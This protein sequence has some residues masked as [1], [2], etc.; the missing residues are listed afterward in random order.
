MD[1]SFGNKAARGAVWAT[2][3]RFG[4]MA[5][6][7]CVNIVLANLLLPSDF[8]VIGMLM[9][10][11][12]VSTVLVDSGFGSALVQKKHP[13][14]VDY[15]TVF[16]WNIGFSVALYSILYVSSP[17]IAT[18]FS[19]PELCSIL[20][21]FGITLVINAVTNIQMT[22]LKKELEF[23][24]IAVA[25]LA[26]YTVASGIGIIMAAK[27]Y[28]AWSLVALT[29]MANT[30]CMLLLWWFSRWKPSFCFDLRSL[31]A[32]FGFGGYIMAASILQ[33]A[34]KN[35]QGLVIGKKF[36]ATQM[37]YYSQASK[38]EE[39][40]CNSF[41]RVIV[42][43]M[44]PVYSSI[45]D[46][47][48]RLISILSMNIRVIA[49]L[50][51]PVVAILMLVADPLISHLY[52]D[53]WLPSAPY[54]RVLCCGGFFT[55]LQNVNFYAVA[56]VGKSRT[57]FLWSF[58]KW[59][60]LLAAILAGACFGMYGI[61]YGM[62]LSSLN[63][64]IVNALLVSR[65]VGLTL[66]HQLRFLLPV[67]AVVLISLAIATVLSFLGAHFMFVLLI[68]AAAYL[69][70]GYLFRLK[71]MSESWVLVKRMLGKVDHP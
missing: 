5:L 49:F 10:F 17:A 66:L 2:I 3:D 42:Q 64:Y 22:R 6:Q 16:Y 8:G 15:S 25:D 58:Y 7:F 18:F 71:A 37:G 11:I 59:G 40:G 52:G 67:S 61:L 26:S 14:Q 47:R 21:V 36:S 30:L 13:T 41:P 48:Q 55:C 65:H 32:L 62:V 68:F 45:Q 56:A 63:I 43:V 1:K 70:M 33:E 44:F 29:I 46:D 23:K 69:S 31:R 9:I 27:G 35:V 34:C 39:A 50:I 51:F 24:K 60:F 57:L 20:R 28:G 4:Y 38:L 54:F 12:A 19:L 53:M